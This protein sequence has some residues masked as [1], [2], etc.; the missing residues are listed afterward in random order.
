MEVSIQSTHLKA[1]SIFTASADVRYYLRGVLAEVRP[2]ETRLAATDGTCAAVLRGTVLVGEQPNMPD[3]IIPNETVKLALLT[4]SQVLSLALSDEG[5]WSLAGISFTPVD[6]KFPGRRKI[7]RLPP[8][9][10]LAS[11][12]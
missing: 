11:E 6:G 10:P 8:N 1:A 5:K 9:H 2:T 7:P 12:W 3:V 4:K